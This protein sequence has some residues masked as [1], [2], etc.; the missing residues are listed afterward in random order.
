VNL[1]DARIPYF[2]VPQAVVSLTSKIALLAALRVY[3]EGSAVSLVEPAASRYRTRKLSDVRWEL[4]R[5]GLITEA[6]GLAEIADDRVSLPVGCD[7]T[8]LSMGGLKTL[9]AC[10]AR[11]RYSRDAFRFTCTQDQL[12]TDAELSPQS[13]RDSLVQLRNQ[14]LIAVEKIWREGSRITLL[15]PEFPS[16]CPIYYIGKWHRDQMDAIPVHERY[17]VCLAQYDP[18]NQLKDVCGPVT[19]YRVVCPFCPRPD[20]KKG[21]LRINTAAECDG[22]HC[23]CCK[24]SG[25]SAR[26]WVKLKWRAGKNDWR[27]VM[28]TT[29]ETTTTEGHVRVALE[30]DAPEQTPSSVCNRPT[31]TSCH[32]GI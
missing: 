9:I 32:S 8:K 25:D 30:G 28:A 14:E 26:L 15:D 29:L 5:R 3:R 21:T 6:L 1:F 19:N 16:G 2:V 7:Y 31:I 22:W 20:W 17:V 12:A 23:H 13:L 18:R 24:R 27:S 4:Q 10:Y 11:A